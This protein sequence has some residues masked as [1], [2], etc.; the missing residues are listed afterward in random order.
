MA[1]PLDIRARLRLPVNPAGR[2]MRPPQIGEGL[3]LYLDVTSL[4][5]QAVAATGVRFT[6]R[7]PDGFA[8]VLQGNQIG[9]EAPGVY[10]VE[11]V[12]EV[13]GD[14]LL[15]AECSGP[16]PAVDEARL[17]VQGSLAAGAGA[18]GPL[19]VT[20]DLWPIAVG[21]GGMLTVTR[22]PALPEADDPIG[23]TLAGA[24]GELAKM[25]R[26]ET[27]E[28]AAEAAGAATGATEGAA[29]GA[30]AGTTAGATAGTT[31]GQAAGAA[32]GAAAAT[33]FVD[34]AT[35]QAGIAT[36]KAS[37]AASS[38]SAANASR[39]VTQTSEAAAATSAANA[40]AL[41][42]VA[43]QRA[44]LT[45]SSLEAVDPYGQTLWLISGDGKTL[46]LISGTLK[47]SGTGIRIASADDTTGIDLDPSAGGP[48]IANAVYAEEAGRRGMA[49]GDDY[50]QVFFE[51]TPEILGGGGWL[52]KRAADGTASITT[53]DG[54]A[55]VTVPPG[56]A[57][58]FSGNQAAATAF[59]A[60]EIAQR[61]ARAL[62]LRAEAIERYPAQLQGLDADYNLILGYGQSN[63]VGAEAWP[64]ISTT[65][66][67]GT[68]MLGYSLQGTS[69]SSG[70]FTPLGGAVFRPLV[71]TVIGDSGAL[72][73]ATAVAALAPGSTN[74]GESHLVNAI[75]TLQALRLADLGATSHPN[76]LVGI[77]CA[78]SGR[79]IAELS[80][81]NAL[82]L[83]NRLVVAVTQAKAIADAE[84]KTIRVAAISYCQG[85]DDYAADT[86]RTQYK[87]ALAQLYADIQQYVCLAI[88]GQ[89][90]PPAMVLT[91]V[92]GRGTVA[93]PSLGNATLEIGQA[94]L[95]ASRETPGIFLAAPYYP[96]TEK[97][98]HL[99]ANGQRW[100]G[101]FVGR[102]LHRL[103][104]K[105]QAWAPLAP[106]TC[107]YRGAQVLMTF[108]TP[109]PPLAF[110][111]PYLVDGVT[112]DVA[113][114]GFDVTDSA[115]TLV[116]SAVQ[117]VGDAALLL[118]CGRALA[119]QPVVHYARR[120]VYLGH[121][122]L[123]DSDAEWTPS[124]FTYLPGSG[125]YATANIPA[126]VDKPYP[127][128]NWLVAG[129]TPATA[130]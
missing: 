25:I 118:T 16:R 51:A 73:D 125:M 77:N 85:E 130:A 84:G 110:G 127:L 12:F 119:S 18:A 59:T 74:P 128:N 111:T 1:L 55:I 66:F 87:A 39:V 36:T 68:L 8:H 95:E 5:G 76:K 37:E 56:G 122:C 7:R 54:T 120:A 115:G 34:Q 53:A 14:W 45:D 4:A 94:Q 99:D 9:E 129:D 80:R 52:M 19:L 32:A 10:W 49:L 114:K 15:R 83:F 89:T 60:A 105:R 78:V 50:G 71:G 3:V 82:N 126:L 79:T 97:G 22:I 38:A 27:L 26:W 109:A 64:A 72:L 58:V 103:L 101:A 57:P 124:N 90:R 117:I 108:H 21:N 20:R 116:V 104:I 33:P 46:R 86:T 61:N 63:T 2:A 40:Q 100:I 75:N 31:A 69:G 113:T 29:S 88:L 121:G 43:D 44:D 91:Q 92:S 106:L 93:S 24:Q 102:V 11:V 6:L 41:T 35:A 13:A 47:P 67:G 28:A 96:V 123:R 30:A 17:I 62:A 48:R 23:M 42:G 70:T 65:P 112:Y 98:I 107:E 81:G